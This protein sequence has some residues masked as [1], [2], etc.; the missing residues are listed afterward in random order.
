MATGLVTS[1]VER[2]A[3]A[4]NSDNVAGYSRHPETI[5]CGV[6]ES[7]ERSVERFAAHGRRELIEAFAILAGPESST[8]RSILDSPHHGSY[9]TV[10]DMLNLSTNGDVLALM[11]AYLT[12]HEAPLAVR[13]VVARRTDAPFA[14]SLLDVPVA[15]PR[16]G[17]REKLGADQVA[18]VLG[19]RPTSVC[20]RLPAERQAAAMRLMAL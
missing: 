18:R 2:L 19:V 5:R 14:A 1:L 3:R 7:L 15:S 13:Q 6:L 9:Q 4:V 10:V 17:A 16:T 20:K 8:L 11:I 12:K